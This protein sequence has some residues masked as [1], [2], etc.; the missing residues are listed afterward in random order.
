[1]IFPELCKSLGYTDTHVKAFQEEQEAGKSSHDNEEQ[2]RE[3]QNEHQAPE[4]EQDTDIA[5]HLRGPDNDFGVF[6][7]SVQV[8]FA[9]AVEEY[10]EVSEVYSVPRV[11]QMASNMGLR[12][13]WAMDICTTD[14]NG[15]RRGS[16]PQLLKASIVF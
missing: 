2:N 11:T 1:M 13:G 10:N 8:G 4:P 12:P 16:L 5:L 6:L 9:M 15:E 14:E 7:N 3:E